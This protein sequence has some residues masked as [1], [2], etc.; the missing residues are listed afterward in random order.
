M[1]TRYSGFQIQPNAPTIQGE[2]EKALVILLKESIPLTGSSRTDAGVH[3]LQNFFHFD[4]THLADTSKLCYQLNCI[5]PND[6]AICSIESVDEQKHCRFDAISRKYRYYVSTVKNPFYIDNS[7]PFYKNLNI[8]LLNN[9]AKMLLQHTDFSSFSKLHTQ[10][11]TN[12][13]ILFESHWYKENNLLVYEVK[14]NR[15]L[16]GMVRAL[17]GTMLHVGKQKY[18]LEEFENIILSKDCNRADFSAPAKG[19]FLAEVNF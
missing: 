17:V 19:L 5:L 13:C 9:A 15:F 4:Y 18:S 3:A 1:G 16:R 10:V 8:E 6:I 12:N 11:K 2:I 7:Y 14:G